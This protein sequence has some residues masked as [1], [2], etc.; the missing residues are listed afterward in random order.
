MSSSALPTLKS[1]DKYC[2]ISVM[3]SNYSPP[4]GSQN[5]SGYKMAVAAHPSPVYQRAK[6]FYYMTLNSDAHNTSGSAPLSRRHSYRYQ[7]S[8]FSIRASDLERKKFAGIY[9][10]F[11]FFWSFWYSVFILHVWYLNLTVLTDPSFPSL[12]VLLLLL[13]LRTDHRS[14]LNATLQL[15]SCLKR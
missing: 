1:Q 4:S 8:P 3:S 7:G 13:R 10:P 5:I 14:D 15:T 2:F 6:P 12:Q 9:I 11:L